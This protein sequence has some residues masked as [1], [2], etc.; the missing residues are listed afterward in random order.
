MYDCGLQLFNIKVVRLVL[1][2]IESY[3]YFTCLYLWVLL[4]VTEVR[5]FAFEWYHCQRLR[6]ENKNH[7]NINNNNITLILLLLSWF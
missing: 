3:I 6:A 4:W 1:P 7:N 2:K 5:A